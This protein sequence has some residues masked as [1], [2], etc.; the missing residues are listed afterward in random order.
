MAA[1]AAAAAVVC[2]GS[3]GGWVIW[4]TTMHTRFRIWGG[5]QLH[6]SGH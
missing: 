6:P 5:V 1:A 4:V 2:G 3:L